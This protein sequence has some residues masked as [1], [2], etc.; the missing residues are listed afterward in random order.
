MIHA[1]QAKTA[2]KRKGLFQ[3]YNNVIE[4]E[5]EPGEEAKNF[6][7]AI[8]NINAISPKSMKDAKDPDQPSKDDLKASLRDALL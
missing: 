4:A 1:Q 2:C 3:D 5:S 6:R 7:E 8:A